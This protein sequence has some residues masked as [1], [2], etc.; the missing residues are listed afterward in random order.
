[1]DNANIILGDKANQENLKATLD[2]LHQLSSALVADAKVG[3]EQLT[4]ALGNWQAD[5]TWTA[6]VSD[7]PVLWKPVT[8]AIPMSVPFS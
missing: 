8:P 2:E 5:A 1:M 7:G 4:P 6:S 3:L